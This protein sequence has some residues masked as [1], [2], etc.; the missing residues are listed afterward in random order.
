[1]SVPAISVE[2]IALG[3]RRLQTFVD[4]PYRLLHG[5]PC[6]TPPLRA[7]F[8]GSRLLSTVG[9]LTPAH[10]YHAQAEVTHF[11]A[12]RNGE[13][14]GRISAAVNRRFNEYH[15]VRVGSFGFMDFVEDYAVAE[16][17]LDRAR[18]WVA[19][20]GMTVF[21]GPGEYSNATHE[22]QGVLIDGFEHPPVVE[23]TH[24]PPYYGAFLDR[25]G[26]AKAMD[27]LA[28]RL[29]LE[30]PMPPRL[31]E[32]A[33]KVLGRRDIGIVPVDMSRFT[34]ELRKVVR[35][36]NDAWADN[37]GYLPLTEA[38]ADAVADQL[39]PIVDPGLV[40]FAYVDGELAAV[41]GAFPDPYW[42]LRPRWNRFQDN[43]AIRVARLL[44]Q[45]RHIPRVR[46]MFFGI[47]SQFR[48]L[49]LDAALFY[50]VMTY[51]VG[52]GYREC[53]IS[54]LLETNKAILQEADFMQARHYKT[55]RIYELALDG[56]SADTGHGGV[57]S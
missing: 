6:W 46:L 49:G 25:Y 16:A 22:R 44:R 8:L 35:V 39:K 10:P 14:V 1:M 54:L 7:D 24:N 36:Y 53:D 55:W 48:R 56:G 30:A 13:L 4:L 28:Y 3:D 43:D 11:I 26:L 42:C 23:L 52:R 40:R 33:V 41:L 27:Y 21:R 34:E 20:R 19:D 57:A 2:Q 12:R 9:L 51:A 15:G 38:E 31:Q 37:W 50:E 47:R 17:L 18:E 5:D 29:D 45:R 32:V